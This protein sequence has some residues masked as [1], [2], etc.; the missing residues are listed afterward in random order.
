MMQLLASSA[1]LGLLATLLYW[2]FKPK[3]A[4]ATSDAVTKGL[5]ITLYSLGKVFL[6]RLGYKIRL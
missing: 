4:G 1:K 5:A 3:K 6:Q 2:V